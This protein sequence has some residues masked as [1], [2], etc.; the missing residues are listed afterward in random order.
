[1]YMNAY[2]AGVLRHYGNNVDVCCVLKG[3]GGGGGGRLPPWPYTCMYVEEP[4]IIVMYLQNI[5]FVH[6]PF[7]S[8]P[9][10][11]S[12]PLSLSLTHSLS[13]L[14]TNIIY[15]SILTALSG[16]VTLVQA[17][18]QISLATSY[19]DELSIGCEFVCN[20]GSLHEPFQRTPQNW[21]ILSVLCVVK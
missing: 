7:D 21:S 6:V 9:P 17:F 14:V 12:P 10:S 13:Y 5:L 19:K 15:L 11:L 8:L 16:V 18:F 2:Q 20:S 4:G 3:L 1:M